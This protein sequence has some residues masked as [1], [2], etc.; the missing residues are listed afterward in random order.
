MG[1]SGL[2]HG[3]TQGM[4]K[5]QLI[6]LFG[7][8]VLIYAGIRYL[9]SPRYLGGFWG[10]ALIVWLIA[11]V[12]LGTLAIG[13]RR[14]N[15]VQRVRSGPGPSREAVARKVDEIEAEMK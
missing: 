13:S 8:A 2:V 1:H 5:K 14:P 10:V 15:P 3:G 4:Q 7:L 11:L 12:T 9:S 6:Y